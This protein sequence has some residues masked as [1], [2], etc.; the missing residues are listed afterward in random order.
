MAEVSSRTGG[1]FASPID[2]SPLATALL[3]ASGAFSIVIVA[4]SIGRPGMPEGYLG[5]LAAEAAYRAPANVRPIW[6][7]GGLVVVG[8]ALGLIVGNHIDQPLSSEEASEGNPIEATEESIARGAM[9]FS[10][11]CT[12]CHGES[13]RGDGPAAPTL[14]L[15]PANLYDHIPIH[16]DQF[17]FGVISKGL[18]G[19][20]PPFENQLSEEDRWN[21]LNYLRVTFTAEPTNR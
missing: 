14:S 7:L 19:V 8:I 11:N 5:W 10:A 4:G 13:G 18:G 2:F 21:I 12:I 6:A 15:Q 20:M 9:L 17:F 3:V 1:R 16:R